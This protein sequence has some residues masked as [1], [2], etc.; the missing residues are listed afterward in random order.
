MSYPNEHVLVVPRSLFDQLGAFEGFSSEVDRYLPEFLKPENNFFM[1]RDT[2]ETDP[3]HK[4]L[5][6]Y[7]LVCHRGKVLHY[8]RGKKSGEQRLASKGSIGIGGH[9]NTDDAQAASLGRSTYET[10]VDREL[11]EELKLPGAYRQ[12]IA[13]LVNDDSNEVG[14][15]HLGVVHVFELESAEVAPNEAPITEL[16][17]L[18]R[19]ELEA[20]RDRLETWSQLLLANWDHIFP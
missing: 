7:A 2:A 5:I 17:F 1:A 10:G 12:R 3:T 15:V 16:E 4:Q 13:G 18:S 6:P 8:V 11:N 14:Q 19:E 20:R 9:V